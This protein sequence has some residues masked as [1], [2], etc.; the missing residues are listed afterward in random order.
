MIVHTSPSGAVALVVEWEPADIS[1][2]AHHLGL[3][4]Q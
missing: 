2:A 3:P 4:L 1:P